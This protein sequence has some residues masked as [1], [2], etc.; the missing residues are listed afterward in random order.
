MFN[1]NNDMDGAVF[2]WKD[3]NGYGV[4]CDVISFTSG[5]ERVDIRYQAIVA[6]GR[7][8]LQRVG[9]HNSGII[10]AWA[11]R[12]SQDDPDMDVLEPRGLPTC[13]FARDRVIPA[14]EALMEV[15]RRLTRDNVLSAH[16]AAFKSQRH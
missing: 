5:A 2:T 16:R 1:C 7:H 9:H 12:G 6:Y 13:V 14:S 8:E 15:G 11:R 3:R 10:V 4:P